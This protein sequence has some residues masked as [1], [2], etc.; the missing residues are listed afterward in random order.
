MD[1]LYIGEYSPIVKK[2]FSNFNK[3]KLD[4]G[5]YRRLKKDGKISRKGRLSDMMGG[6]CIG[7]QCCDEG[8]IY[9]ANSDKCI[10]QKIAPFLELISDINSEKKF[11]I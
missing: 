6:T 9:D 1:I 10:Y 2:L 5:K 4:D 3:Y 11:E 7:S 8:M